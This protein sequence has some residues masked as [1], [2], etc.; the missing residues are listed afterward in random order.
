[1]RLPLLA[2]VLATALG[3]APFATAQDNVPASVKA[4]HH[5]MQVNGYAMGILGAMAKGE[6][7]YDAAMAASAAKNIHA[8]AMTDPVSLWTPGTEQ[9]ASPDSRA[10]PEIWSDMEGFKAAFA[11]FEQA[12]AKLAEAAGTDLEAM[13]AA[14]GPVG[15]GCGDCHEKFRGPK[16]E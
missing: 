6:A 12:S 11:D 9:G 13:K 16:N 1:M 3:P 5:V 7:D 4:R 14:M 8:M 10:K 2:A 15:K